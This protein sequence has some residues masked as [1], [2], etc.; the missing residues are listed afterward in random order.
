MRSVMKP[1]E[2]ELV[3]TLRGAIQRCHNPKN[4]GYRHYGGRGI[5]VH[6]AWR[7]NVRA[8]VKHVGRKPTEFHSL[9]RIDNDGNYEPGNVRWATGKEQGSNRQRSAKP[10]IRQRPYHP[11]LEQHL[12]L[13]LVTLQRTYQTVLERR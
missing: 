3:N 2:R 8:F 10:K 12:P 5:T 9:D 7:A 13:T 4:A 1:W 11:R 6:E